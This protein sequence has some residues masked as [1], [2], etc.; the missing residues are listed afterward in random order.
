MGSFRSVT[1]RWDGVVVRAPAKGTDMRYALL[2][3]FSVPIP[4]PLFI[5]LF[6]H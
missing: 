6:F 1:T 3:L 5:W 4:I 2:W